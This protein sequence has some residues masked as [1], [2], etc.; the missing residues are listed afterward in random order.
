MP[1]ERLK[2]RAAAAAAPIDAYAALRAPGVGVIAEVKRASPSKGPLAEIPD[3]AALAR[4]YA[5]GG[6]RE[7][8]DAAP[9]TSR[10]R[11]GGAAPEGRRR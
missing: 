4:E 11:R 9:I 5:D 7:H 3:A 6:A 1:L 2:E 8:H 10:A